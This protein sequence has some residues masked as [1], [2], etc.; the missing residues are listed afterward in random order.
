MED[1]KSIILRQKKLDK[2]YIRYW[3]KDFELTKVGYRNYLKS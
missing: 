2:N 3:L 1:I